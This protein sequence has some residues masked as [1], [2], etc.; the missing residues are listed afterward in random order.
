M[1]TPSL[2]PREPATVWLMKREPL[3]HSVELHF[4]FST[5]PENR[6]TL[7]PQCCG[8]LPIGSLARR[9][10]RR[11]TG[12]RSHLGH[13]SLFGFDR[14]QRAWKTAVVFGKALARGAGC[15][16][17]NSSMTLEESKKNGIG[18]LEWQDGIYTIHEILHRTAGSGFHS[19]FRGVVADTQVELTHKPIAGHG[20]RQWQ[21]TSRGLARDATIR[22]LVRTDEV[23]APPVDWT[24]LSR[25]GRLRQG[26]WPPLHH[27]ARA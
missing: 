26:C 4:A 7:I 22:L 6:R 20:Y 24:F 18:R 9:G 2:G 1:P 27:S 17:G 8:G 21:G 5:T 11:R 10:D 14:Q 12:R 13:L 16:A 15:P 23:L 19:R 3:T 25:P